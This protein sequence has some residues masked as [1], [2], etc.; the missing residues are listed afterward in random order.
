MR[1]LGQ[2][3]G[4]QRDAPRGTAEGEA[5]GESLQRA[6]TRNRSSRSLIDGVVTSPKDTDAK[7]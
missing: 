5:A 6:Q 7:T 1:L 4:P 3:I 2:E